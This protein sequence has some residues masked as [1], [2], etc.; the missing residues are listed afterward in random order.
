MPQYF[1]SSAERDINLF[2]SE[3]RVQESILPTYY[4]T[5][6]IAQETKAKRFD[7]ETESINHYLSQHQDDFN[8]YIKANTVTRNIAGLQPVISFGKSIDVLPKTVQKPLTNGL[9]VTEKEQDEIVQKIGAVVPNLLPVSHTFDPIKQ[10]GAEFMKKN[11]DL[12]V[13]YSRAYSGN[14]TATSTLFEQDKALRQLYKEKRF[15]EYD[16]E[17]LSGEAGDIFEYAFMD[18]D[19]NGVSNLNNIRPPQQLAGKLKINQH[20]KF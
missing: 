17:T 13:E 8:A 6:F 2:D 18:I 19:F 15:I 3:R 9:E 7:P 4:R 12:M 10:T 20:V 1:N 11:I 16:L 14:A 5:S